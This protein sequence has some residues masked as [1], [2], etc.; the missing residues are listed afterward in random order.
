MDQFDLFG[1]DEVHTDIKLTH[2]PV[3]RTVVDKPDNPDGLWTYVIQNQLLIWPGEEHRKRSL[4]QLKAFM[5]FD[6]AHETMALTDFGTDQIDAFILHML[7]KGS[8]KA[9]INRYSA[10]LSRIF[11]YAYSKRKY[12]YPVKLEFF[13]EKNRNRVRVYNES[14]LAEMKDWFMTEGHEWLW[15]MCIVASKAGM[16][17]MEIVSI[18]RPVKGHMT[19]LTADKKWLMLPPEIDKNGKGRK[20]AVNNPELLEAIEYLQIALQSKWS[21]KTF[22]R[23]WGK[24]RRDVFQNEEAAVFHALRHTCA[25]NMANKL[26]LNSLIIAEALGHSTI[27]TT[28][29]YVHANDDALQAASAQM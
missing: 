25:S 21:D 14:E 6:P 28:Q 17:R 23:T 5:E 8:S 22:Y 11:N 26:K 9:T 7:N 15:K 29:K 10:T 16:R 3:T 24:M 27:A 2:E 20:I 12:P 18:G 13:T 4:N 1:L 19:P